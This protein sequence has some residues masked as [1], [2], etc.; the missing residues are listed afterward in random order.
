MISNRPLGEL[1]GV[2]QPGER[3]GS[4]SVLLLRV[5]NLLTLI[6]VLPSKGPDVT[7]S[8]IV[9]VIKEY[10]GE[11]PYWKNHWGSPTVNEELGECIY[12]ELAAK[13][14]DLCPQYLRT[15]VHLMAALTEVNYFCTHRFH[16]L[17][18]VSSRTWGLHLWKRRL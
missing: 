15:T 7:T 13:N 17:T 3:C 10:L 4:N 18:T 2:P 12:D 9:R 16:L 8:D 1:S 5:Y 11:M 6:T 14:W